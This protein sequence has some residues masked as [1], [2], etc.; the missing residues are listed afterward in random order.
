VRAALLSVLI[1]VGVMAGLIG[2]FTWSPWDS[3]GRQ[4][5]RAWLRSLDEWR[6]AYGGRHGGR[7]L[8]TFAARVGPAPTERMKPVAGAVRDWCR[9]SGW[10]GVESSLVDA[11]SRT[12]RAAREADFSRIAA[13]ISGVKARVYCWPEHDWTPFAQDFELVV[14]DEFWI[15]GLATPPTRIDLSPDVCDPLRRFFRG[16]YQPYLNTQSYDL[17]E[18]IVTLAHES[19]HLRTPGASEAVV[20]CHALQR[21]RA[22]VRLAGRKPWYQ[23]EM[24]GLAWE[25]GYPQQ[26]ADYRTKACRNGGPLDL[27]PGSNAWP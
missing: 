23:K 3:E 5:E 1:G 12:A 27:H 11:H 18:A 17:A 25:V 7:C 9:G 4:H 8:R 2:V 24:T 20:E 16:S 6:T 26:F 14:R 13:S 21:A 22:L 10:D 19:E 15:A